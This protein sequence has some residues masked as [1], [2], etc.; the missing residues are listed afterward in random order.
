M[1]DFKINEKKQNLFPSLTD[2]ITPIKQQIRGENYSNILSWNV[3]TL[4]DLCFQTKKSQ[5][6]VQINVKVKQRE[7]KFNIESVI[8]GARRLQF[9][10]FFYSL[11]KW[12][13]L[14]L[15]EQRGIVLWIESYT[16]WRCVDA[17]PGDCCDIYLPSWNSLC[18][19]DDFVFY[20]EKQELWFQFSWKYLD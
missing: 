5:S 16:R 11:W 6:Q 13:S 1:C 2:T 15:L 20:S 14:F 9:Y 18:H 4:S 19:A 3:T 10:R 17:A 12:I 7:K 8:K